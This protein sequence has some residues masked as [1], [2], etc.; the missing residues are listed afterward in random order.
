MKKD[1][2]KHAAS[3]DSYPALPP[4]KGEQRS[5]F[6]VNSH[7]VA[8]PQAFQ[9]LFSF[10]QNLFTKKWRKESIAYSGACLHLAF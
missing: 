7:W 8:R 2:Q 6:K 3:L 10:P 5:L 1:T 9:D 4:Q